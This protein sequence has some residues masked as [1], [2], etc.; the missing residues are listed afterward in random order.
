MYV[1]IVSFIFFGPAILLQLGM[2]VLVPQFADPT[3]LTY[4]PFSEPWPY[5]IIAFGM[6]ILYFLRLLYADSKV[7]EL[8]EAK[9]Y[10]EIADDQIV[11][12]VI[13]RKF[14][15]TIYLYFIRRG[16]CQR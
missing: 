16:R 5:I 6:G 11:D 3:Y 14:K 15:R 12:T 4:A 10:T 9:K 1:Y 7:F 2:N 13:G 8:K